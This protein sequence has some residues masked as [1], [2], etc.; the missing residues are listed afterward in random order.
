MYGVLK[1]SGCP[2]GHGR[3]EEGPSLCFEPSTV[4]P[5]G[6]KLHVA[7]WAKRTC[8]EVMTF[9]ATDATLS[10]VVAHMAPSTYPCLT[11]FL[12]RP[13]KERH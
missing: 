2:G 8:P 13:N 9:S 3:S 7:V 5:V 12:T 1:P 6:S 11:A 10:K 4:R